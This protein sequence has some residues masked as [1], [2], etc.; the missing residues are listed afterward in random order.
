MDDFGQNKSNMIVNSVFCD[1]WKKNF[2]TKSYLKVHKR[3]H[4]GEKPFKCDFCDKS[5]IVKG[6]LT[7]HILVHSG[8]RE[9]QC[10]S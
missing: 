10:L 5:F 6:S 4:T 9:F 1:V 2:K 8:I 3:V 7:K